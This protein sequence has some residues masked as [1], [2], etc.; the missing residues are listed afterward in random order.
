MSSK[1]SK[2]IITNNVVGVE[3]ECGKLDIVL[4]HRPG[5]ELLRLTKDNL[6][7]LLYDAI[8]DLQETHKS[9]DQF[10]QYLRDHGSQVLYVK[11]LLQ[12]T[13]NSN[14][15]AR[16]TL[17]NGIISN[18][19]FND[20][21]QQEV[22]TALRQW[23]LARKPDE[24]AEDVIVGVAYS[25]G[26]LGTS[27]AAQIL[28]NKGNFNSAFLI[29]PLPNLLFSRDAFSVI[30]KNVF[31]WQ[32][33]KPARRNEPLIL[34]VVFQYHP[35]LSTSGLK[36]IEWRT[37]ANTHELP[38]VEG[39]DVAYLGQGVLLIGCSERTNR[40]GIEALARTGLFRRVIAVVLPPQRD[41]MHL[42]TVLS[43]VGRHA[44]TLHG[45]LANI[46]EVFTVATHDDDNNPFDKP[47]WTSYGCDVRQALRKVL[48][49][50]EL[51]FY[52][53]QD[54]KTSIDEQREC[55]HN[56][57][58]LDDY[59]VVTYAGGDLEKGI[60]FEMIRNNSCRVGLIPN[61]GLLEGGGG[62]HCM[63]NALRRSSI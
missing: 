8:P 43:S 17:I 12:E 55:R 24:L 60:A 9:H 56:V 44:F 16:N 23:L 30:E 35:Q 38:T 63:T 15:E 46:M 25:E 28:L 31:I 33:A 32:M 48:N 5:Q 2:N 4:M 7:N 40:A 53:T 49:D 61:K 41:Y 58:V 26:E 42:D 18:C 45:R 14:D 21:C 29:P 27:P 3:S 22:S 13:L 59:H 47:E 10:S 39:G 6:Q 54:E 1:A 62:V 57:F 19:P 34:R 11:E 52:D 51:I 50:S 20:N 36:I 37:T